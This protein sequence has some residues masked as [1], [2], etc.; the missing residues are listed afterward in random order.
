MSEELD[1]A[2]APRATSVAERVVVGSG[3]GR[4]LWF[5]LTASGSLLPKG[6][7]VVGGCP[8]FLAVS[9]TQALA[10]DEQGS[11]LYFLSQVGRE[12]RLGP[13]SASGGAGPAYVAFDRASRFALVAN[14]GSG[15]VSVFELGG[16][17]AVSVQQPSQ[18]PHAIVCSPA[19]RHALVPCLGSDRIAIYAFDAATGQ[20]GFHGEAATPAGSGPRHLTFDASGLLVYVTFEHSSEIGVFG[21]DEALGSLEPIGRASMLGETASRTGNTAAHLELHP[22]G[23]ALYASN[24]GDDSLAVF[25]VDG[26]GGIQLRDRI[27]TGRTPRHFSINRS[28]DRILVGNLDSASVLCLEVSDHGQKLAPLAVTDEVPQP[29]FVGFY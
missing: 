23:R 1:A 20:L 2:P 11:L 9:G 22:S 13:A 17:N 27:K 25:A 21:W 26:T 18:H 16:A 8:S 5:E 10:V 28:G 3:A 4:L 24:R 15:S 14:Y 12:A 7:L 19:N 29:F 6:Q